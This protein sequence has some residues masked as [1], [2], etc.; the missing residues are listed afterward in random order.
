MAFDFSVYDYSV[1]CQREVIHHFLVRNNP[2][3]LQ[4]LVWLGMKWKL[5]LF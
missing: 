4:V 2:R 3:G 1:V 5:E